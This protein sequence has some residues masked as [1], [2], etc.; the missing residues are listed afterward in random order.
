[1]GTLGAKTSEWFPLQ[2]AP[3]SSGAQGTSPTCHSIDT[4]LSARSYKC[5]LPVSILLLSLRFLIGFR[6]VPKLWYF[7]LS[8]ILRMKTLILTQ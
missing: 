6:T 1:M 3:P 7:L 5:V 8:H 2:V 4:T